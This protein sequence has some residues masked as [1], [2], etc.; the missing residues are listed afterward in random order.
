[1]WKPFNIGWSYLAAR[2]GRKRKRNTSSFGKIFSSYLFWDNWPRKGNIN[3]EEKVLQSCLNSYIYLM[4]TGR[5]SKFEKICS[6]GRLCYQ[7][8]GNLEHNRL[9]PSNLKHS[10]SCFGHW[11]A[12]ASQSCFCSWWITNNGSL[13]IKQLEIAQSQIQADYID[14]APWISGSPRWPQ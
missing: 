2:N 4:G 14:F 12:C 3:M 13:F 8:S 9:N 10:L 7:L 5:H 6:G 11:P 1:M